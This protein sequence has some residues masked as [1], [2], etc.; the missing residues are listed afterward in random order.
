MKALYAERRKLALA[1]VSAFLPGTLAAGLG[2]IAPLPPRADDRAIVDM[3]RARG[4]APSALSAWFLG[5]THAQRGLLLSVTNLRSD[6][7][8]AACASLESIVASH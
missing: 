5:R 3:A 7:I 4:L 6:N 8:G 1:R 2:L